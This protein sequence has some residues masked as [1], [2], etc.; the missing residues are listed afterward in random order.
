[1]MRM[2]LLLF[3]ALAAPLCAQ[4]AAPQPEECL[5]RKGEEP[6]ATAAFNERT[7]GFRTAA[8]R[9]QFLADPERYSQLYDALAE[10]A[11]AGEKIEAPQ[12][13][14]VPS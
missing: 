7:Y 3:V 9:D 12:A 5:P 2:V 14:L 1:M 10:L 4:T 8:C 11:A 13:S 6:A